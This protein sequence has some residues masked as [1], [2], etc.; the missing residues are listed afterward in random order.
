MSGNKRITAAV[1]KIARLHDTSQL[2]FM[3]D[4]SYFYERYKLSFMETKIFFST[5]I[6]TNV[7]DHHHLLIWDISPK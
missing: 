3:R 5:Q 4:L 7:L 1:S 2:F 6:T